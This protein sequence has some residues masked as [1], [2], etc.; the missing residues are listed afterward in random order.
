MEIPEIVAMLFS[1]PV[2]LFVLVVVVLQ[3]AIKFVPQNRAYVIQRFGKFK[4]VQDAGLNFVV[5]FIDKIAADRSLK[6]TAVNVPSQSAITKDNISLAVDGVLYFRVVDPV[7][8][9]YGVDDYVFAVT[10]LAQTT[11]RSELGKMELD[12]TF[13]ER[14]VLNTNIVTS[15]NQAS[16]PWGIQVLRYEIKDIEPPQSVMEAME[17]QMRAERV[18]RAQILESEGDR[19]AAINRAE[20]DKAAVVLSAEADKE[21]KIL[22]AQ[23]EALALIA[24]ADA[25]A[26]ALV[27]IGEAAN[28]NAGQKAVQLDLASKA[29]EA[30]EKIA[31]ESTIVLLPDSSN[32]VASLVAQSMAIIEKISTKDTKVSDVTPDNQVPPQPWKR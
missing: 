5:P 7:K 17:K 13:E 4:E 19:Q 18:K 25:K 28:S 11:M 30:K 2:I 26:K 32:D 15:I 31:K 12:K 3:R 22:L 1:F 8:A 29:I 6:E 27:V 9:T 16:A 24:V 10:Q 21:E 20:G 14:D 23:G